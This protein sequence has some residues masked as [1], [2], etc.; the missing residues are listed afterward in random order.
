MKSLKVVNRREKAEEND[1]NQAFMMIRG[2][3][4]PYRESFDVKDFYAETKKDDFDIF[5]ISKIQ[6]NE[7]SEGVWWRG[8]ENARFLTKK[9]KSLSPVAGQLRIEFEKFRKISRIKRRSN[10]L[11]ASL[12]GCFYFQILQIK[13]S[14]IF[15]QSCFEIIFRSSAR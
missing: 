4:Q 9:K 15:V 11:K 1:R 10:S 2:H 14:Q 7:F 6:P 8:I 5:A 12:N 3:I 13:L